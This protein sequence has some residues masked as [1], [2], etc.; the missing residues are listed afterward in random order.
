MYV[1]LVECQQDTLDECPTVVG[2]NLVY[3]VDSEFT[4]L[5]YSLMQPERHIRDGVVICYHF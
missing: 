1:L 2:F 4:Y 5:G 3:V